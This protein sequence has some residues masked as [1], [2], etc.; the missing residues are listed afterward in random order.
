MAQEQ[1]TPTTAA[2]HPTEE[3]TEP[4]PGHLEPKPQPTVSQAKTTRS[5]LEAVVMPGVQKHQPT[6]QLATHPTTLGQIPLL[7]LL[8]PTMLLHQV[9]QC[10][11]LHLHH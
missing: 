11:L 5:A 2:E 6:L 10:L 8:T 4:P 1:S 3:E 7:K 9:Q